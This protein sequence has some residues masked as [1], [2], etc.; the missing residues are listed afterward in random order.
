[1]KERYDIRAN[2]GNYEACSKQH[3]QSSIIITMDIITVDTIKR[4]ND[5]INWIRRLNGKAIVINVNHLAPFLVEKN[6]EKNVL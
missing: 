5:V 4:V 3:Y 1:M 6:E 2:Q